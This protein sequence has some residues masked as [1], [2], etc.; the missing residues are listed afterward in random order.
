MKRVI[1]LVAFALICGAMFAQG[2][3]M[4][5]LV[6]AGFYTPSYQCFY[7]K[8]SNELDAKFTANEWNTYELQINKDTITYDGMNGKHKNMGIVRVKSNTEKSATPL[9]IYIDNVT[10]KDDKGKT[11]LCVDFENGQTGGHYFSQGRPMEG[12]GKVVEK[13]GR[14][15]FLINMKS[16]NLYGYNGVEVQWLLPENKKSKDGTWDFSSGKFSVSYD[17][18]IEVAE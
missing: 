15:C 7:M 11:I 4:P 18:F 13:D 5:Q 10:V 8:G 9:V 3:E 17:Y 16:Q 6:Q 2:G 12:N 1:F 14:K